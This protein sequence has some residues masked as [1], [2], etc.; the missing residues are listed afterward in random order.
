MTL[1][2]CHLIQDPVKASPS[3]TSFLD[4]GRRKQGLGF[5]ESEWDEGSMS[6]PWLAVLCSKNVVSQRVEDPALPR[7]S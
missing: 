5:E 2:L 1:R 6:L 4:T 7:L 3:M